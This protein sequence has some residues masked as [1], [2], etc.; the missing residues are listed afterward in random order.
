M[1][2]RSIIEAKFAWRG[3]RGF[4]EIGKH[5]TKVQII[6]QNQIGE[7]RDGGRGDGEG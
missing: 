3:W 1:Y 4:I 2:L 6:G 5:L 7:G